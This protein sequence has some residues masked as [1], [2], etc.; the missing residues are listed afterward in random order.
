MTKGIDISRY[1]GAP[2]FSRVKN[3]VDFVILQAGFGK[4]ASQKDTEFERNYSECKKYGIPVGA[5]WYSYAKSAAEA[6]AEANACLEVI[7]G[8]QF[9]YP[10][11]YDLEEGL[12]ALGQKTVSAIA[13]TFC[14][15]LEK[16]GYFAGIYISRSPAQSYLTPEVA[17]RYALWLAEYGSKCNY[18]GKFGMWQYSSEGRV[19]G[20][21]GN[22]DMDYCYEDY[23]TLIK[24][25]GLNG[26]SK[27]ES[28]SAFD[29]Y[30]AEVNG[31]GVDFDG[32]YGVQC[33]DLVN[34]YAFKVLRCKPFIGMYAWE[35]YE[36]FAAQPSA[37]RFTKIANTPEFVPKK[38]DIVIWAKSL[39]GKAGH[40]AVATG[41]GD[42]TW[43][44]SYE[45]NWTGKNDPC[46]IVRH[47]YSHVLG[48][49]RPKEQASATGEALKPLDTDGFKR[50][51][52]SLG[53]Y[54]LK[55]RLRNLGY[56]V[57]DTQGFGGGTEKA[58]NALLKK[59]GY[60][61]NGV[62]GQGFIRFVM[63]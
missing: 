50:G 48:V 18:D 53:V 58:V 8:K 39:N 17:N 34:D 44:T 20:I 31:K 29:R 54:A 3:S 14:N 37:A 36:N 57:D 43:F 55:Q 41:A 11:Y 45:Q 61:Q 7:K 16:A 25:A 63:R 56:T 6:L 62:A 24:N 9:K 23:P 22:V 30:F 35:I 26:F 4:Y 47:D 5:Y 13:A 1:Q 49:L 46:T 60:A 51:D 27:T 40:C 12:A 21:S 10:I 59:W 42:T 28:T 33:F 15:A 2:D 52:K 38:G 32:A 19:D